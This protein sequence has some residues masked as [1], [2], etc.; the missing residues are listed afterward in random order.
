MVGVPHRPLLPSLP[1]TR[2]IHW[3]TS[4]SPHRP[5][6]PSLPTRRLIHWET[7]L[8]H[9]FGRQASVPGLLNITALPSLR[10]QRLEP[11]I[12]NCETRNPES[13]TLDPEFKTLDSQIL[14]LD[15]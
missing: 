13:L 2:L 9:G 3:T 14:T 11:E 8:S 4:L 15:S 12:L 1:T 10:P 7:S 5:L 6:L